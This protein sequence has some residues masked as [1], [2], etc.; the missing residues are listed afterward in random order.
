[1]VKVD[2]VDSNGL[3]RRVLLKNEYDNPQKG[4]PIDVYETINEL[5]SNATNEF[6]NGFYTRLWNMGLVEP[7]NFASNDA[8]TKVRQCLNASLACD[9]TDLTRRILSIT[10]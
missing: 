5:Y 7:H 4:I 1:M 3:N 8:K 6:K 9:A 10:E 2:Y